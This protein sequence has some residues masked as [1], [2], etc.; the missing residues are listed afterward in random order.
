MKH[1]YLIFLM[2]FSC[3]SLANPPE[4]V[5]RVD[6][7]SPAE[8]QNTNGFQPR[9]NN[10][11]LI[12]HIARSSGTYS[13]YISTTGTYERV[14]AIATALARFNSDIGSSNPDWD[15]RQSALWVYAIRTNNSFYNAAATLE[16][17]IDTDGGGSASTGTLAAAE[18]ILNTA[19]FQDEWFATRSI[20][21]SQVQYALPIRITATDNGD[22]A[23]IGSEDER[24]NLQTYSPDRTRPSGRPYNISGSTSQPTSLQ[25]IRDSATG[26]LAS[27]AFCISN[28][29]P[30]IRRSIQ[31]CGDSYVVDV[32]NTSNLLS[33][34]NSFMRNFRKL[35]FAKPNMR[36][37]EVNEATFYHPDYCHIDLT[38]DDVLTVRCK[39][40]VP[41]TV[42]VNG[43]GTASEWFNSSFWSDGYKNDNTLR[44][45]AKDVPVKGSISIYFTNLEEYGWTMKQVFSGEEWTWWS[46]II[47]E[48]DIQAL[49]YHGSN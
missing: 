44:I 22:A 25:R 26:L 41:F 6:T 19:V 39:Y 20:P 16:H 43:G 33:L 7:R 27:F 23:Q 30:R 17:F 5:Y 28:Q 47:I 32:D 15:S 1:T 13:A 48:P 24:V 3:L 38:D 37:Y 8:I 45:S 40:N 31:T 4:F 34:D 36:Y 11:N 14:S 21:L 9:G 12:E 46:N 35:Q 42:R 49:E 18:K 29:G 10:Q 2:F